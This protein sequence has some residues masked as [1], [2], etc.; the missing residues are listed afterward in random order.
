MINT[1]VSE[2][3]DLYPGVGWD[4]PNHS[5]TVLKYFFNIYL[6]VLL[7][8]SLLYVY[9]HM[10]LFED[11]CNKSCKL[12]FTRLQEKKIKNNNNNK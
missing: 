11:F 4:H 8:N 10:C 3:W 6:V 12:Q 2:W 9:A 1:Y 5:F 7:M